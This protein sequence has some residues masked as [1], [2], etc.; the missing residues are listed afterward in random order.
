MICE[1]GMSERLGL[2]QLGKRSGPVFLGRDFN[3]ER[4]Y[5]E[6]VAAKIDAE[7]RAVVDSCFEKAT[8]LLTENRA[9]MDRIVNV[10][11]EK[12]TLSAED[13]DRIMNGEPEPPELT[14]TQPPA[15]P[16]PASEVTIEK[17]PPRTS[18][19]GLTPGLAGA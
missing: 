6:E 14:P 7:V 5:S 16:T 8:E 3:E 9:V 10:L 19:G 17:V 12:E 1:F 4:N 13:L 18:P 2:V 11:L 15:P